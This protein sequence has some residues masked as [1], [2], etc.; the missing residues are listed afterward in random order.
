M[1]TKKLT[2]KKKITEEPSAP[3]KLLTGKPVTAGKAKTTKAFKSRNSLVLQE[4]KTSLCGITKEYAKSRNLCKVTFILP[5]EAALKAQH[6]AIVG[7][8]NNWNKTTTALSKKENGDFSVAL[9]LETGREYRFRYLIDNHRWE[10][11]WCADK[12]L[13]GPYGE[14]DSVVCV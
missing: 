10:N 8:F 2:A 14:E 1:N 9:E 11:D 13:A 12:Y 4:S 7:D 6:V 3:E 5:G